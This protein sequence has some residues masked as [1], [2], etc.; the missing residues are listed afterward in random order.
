MEINEAE[1]SRASR[2]RSGLRS[3]SGLRLRRRRLRGER[4]GRSGGGGDGGR[5]DNDGENDD[6]RNIGDDGE[7]R[8]DG[9]G[10][11]RGIGNCNGK[12]G[13]A[14]LGMRRGGKGLILIPSALANSPAL[15][16][17]SSASVPASSFL[18]TTEAGEGGFGSGGAIV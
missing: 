4:I 7:D 3:G 5:S 14:D 6:V 11:T 9:G 13:S 15:S 1:S 12:I 10:V 16:S 18:T 8:D 17:S 2:S